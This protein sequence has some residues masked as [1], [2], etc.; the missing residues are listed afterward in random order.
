M[1]NLLKPSQAGT[2]E[3]GDVMVSLVPAELGSGIFVELESLVLLQY[4][5]AIRQTVQDV[6]LTAGIVDAKIHLID[7]GALDCTIRARLKAAISR[8]GGS[9][10]GASHA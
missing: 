10:G 8:A 7:R 2:L 9:E 1:A 4:G 6:F 5:A 3:S